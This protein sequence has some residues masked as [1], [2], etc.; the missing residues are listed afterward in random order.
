MKL[1][2]FTTEFRDLI[3]IVAAD[4]HL[5]ESAIERDYYI[6]LLLKNL[7]I[8]KMQLNRLQTVKMVFIIRNT[9]KPMPS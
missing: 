1:H 3:S 7:A 4:K 8:I 5:P 6:V 2:E 9:R